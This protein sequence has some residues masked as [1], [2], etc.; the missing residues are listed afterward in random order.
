MPLMVSG[1]VDIGEKSTK[2]KATDIVSLRELTETGDQAG[3]I[4]TSPPPDWSG[5]QLE[6]LKDIISRYP[7]AADHICRSSFRTVR[8]DHQSAGFMHGGGKRRFITGS[9]E[10]VGL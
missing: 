7:G 5:Q 6:S 1:T 10:P 3:S 9:E 8:N 2:I 4:S